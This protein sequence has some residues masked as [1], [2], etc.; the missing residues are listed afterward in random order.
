M[1]HLLPK[2]SEQLSPGVMRPCPFPDELQPHIRSSYKKLAL[3]V[4]ENDLARLNLDDDTLVVTCD[5]L[6]WHRLSA[7]KQHVVYYELGILNQKEPDKLNTDL[8]NHANS[9][10]N[11]C[12]HD[13]TLF[14][15]VS[16]GRLFGGEMAMAVMNFYRI[17]M[18]I[19][20][21]VDLFSP[22]E[23]IFVDFRYD[24]NHLSFDLR[25]QLVANFASDLNLQFTDLSIQQ[26]T[27]G[28]DTIAIYRMRPTTY[29]REALARCYATT[30]DSVTRIRCALFKSG[31][32]VLVLVNTNIAEPLVNAFTSGKLVP[33]FLARTIPKRLNIIA[34]CIRY[35]IML[36]QTAQRNPDADDLARLGN[37][38]KD[39]KALCTN[40][41]DPFR[42]FVYSYVQ[43]NILNTFSLQE[44]AHEVLAAEFILDKI[45]PSRIVVDGVRG[46]RSLAYIELARARNIAVDYTWH[47]PQTPQSLKM[48]ALG[49]DPQQPVF[50]D[51]CLSW[52]ET[53]NEWFHRIGAQQEIVNIGSPLR[54][55][56]AN[57]SK[58]PISAKKSLA[59]TNVLIL[60]YG[61]NVS[62][63]A[64]V[65]ANMYGTFVKTVRLLREHGYHNIILK[66]HPGPGRWK[67]SQFEQIQDFFEL[68]CEIQMH[69]PFQD[70]LAWADVV[71][72]PSHTGAMFETLAANKPYHALL[73]PP[74]CTFDKSYFGGF[75]LIESLKDLPTALQRDNTLAERKVL[76]NLYSINKTPNP[77]QRFWQVLSDDRSDHSL[78]PN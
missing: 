4:S 24:I 68:D 41:S 17:S 53:N 6:M 47:A 54:D 21:L 16:L 76:D 66:M 70:C 37:I 51:R 13:P 11:E 34:H 25:K 15:N 46:R 2:D 49:G 23:I 38:K 14:H 7:K 65:N 61:F 27:S 20:G 67:K 45:R 30:L 50:V 48:G 36:A 10:I 72:G 59:N 18:S 32:R 55:R 8:F 73:L 77:S 42:A 40:A 75:P 71:I 52:G 62:D 57:V 69:E 19:H 64:G 43:Y 60:Q 63:L 39:L 74:H 33:V 35:G 26:T 22:K 12:D 56:Y 9:W 1:T 58:H 44:A 3:V 29:F 31:P 78:S 28:P 5:W